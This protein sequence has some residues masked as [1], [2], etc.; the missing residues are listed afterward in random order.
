MV[1]GPTYGQKKDRK[2]KK[3]TTTELSEKTRY[4]EADLFTRA[5]SQRE[6]GNLETALDLY[7][8]AL[9]LNPDDP[10]A[11]YESARI[12]MALG[13]NDEAIVDAKKAV[14]LDEGNRWYKVLYANL[15]KATGKYDEYVR[16]YAEL[17]EKYPNDLNFLNELAFAYYFVG[18]YQ[19]SVE[20]YDRIEQM[21][22]INERLSTQKVQ[23][24]DR[25]GKKEE[26]IAE[27]ERLIAS[28]PEEPRYYALL[29]E[30]CAKNKM[31]DKAIW[32]YEKIVELN[33]D[34]PYVHISLA[35]YYKKKGDQERSFEELKLGLANPS[36]D[37]KTKINLL[38]AYYSG[39]L[40]E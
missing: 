30:Y 12:L 9:Q 31:N 19:K 11:L 29:A 33:P 20:V 25:I 17:V 22:G 10:A 27:Y 35:D 28:D 38:F 15:S 37:L 14:S 23:L 36:L 8:Q 32:A 34:D 18:E 40:S 26:A 1:S 24:Y 6:L 39:N 7:G 4:D 16:L 2:K 3:E 13:R 21:I 5:V